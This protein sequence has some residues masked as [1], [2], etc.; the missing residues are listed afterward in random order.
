V[1]R[2][3]YVCQRRTLSRS[4]MNVLTERNG[5]VTAARRGGGWGLLPVRG[6]GGKAGE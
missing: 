4:E 1:E 6:R 5:G 3:E 2:S